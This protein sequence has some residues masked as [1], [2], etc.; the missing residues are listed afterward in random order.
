MASPLSPDLTQKQELFLDALKEVGTLRKAA[1]AA[2]VGRSTIQKWRADNVNGFRDRFDA[3]LDD[4]ADL[5]ETTMFD[6]INEMKVGH[7][8][9]L[10][11]FALKALRPLKYRELTQVTDEKAQ[12]L[13]RKLEDWRAPAKT[14]QDKKDQPEVNLTP[15]EQVERLLKD[16]NDAR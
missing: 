1:V 5:L 10:L 9:T 14:E 12:D 4:F 8:P 7:N 6:L 2:H 3:A 11:I 16:N 15:L 13:L